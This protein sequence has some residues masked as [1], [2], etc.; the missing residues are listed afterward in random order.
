VGV[1]GKPVV[2]VRIAPGG[3][4]V[5]V[6]RSSGNRLFVDHHSVSKFHAT[7]QMTRDGRLVVTDLGST[8]GT[9]VNAETTQISGPRAVAPGDTIAFGDVA[10]RLEKV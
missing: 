7:V 10:F 2:R 5:T 8:N 1:A 3:D 9:F 4:P 6:G